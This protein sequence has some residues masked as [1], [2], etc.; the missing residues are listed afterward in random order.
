MCDHFSKMRNIF[1]SNHYNQNLL[2]VTA[3]TFDADDLNFSFV[4]NLWQATAHPYFD[5]TTDAN[6]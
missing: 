6:Y 1:Q 3:I 5:V 4:F 2:K